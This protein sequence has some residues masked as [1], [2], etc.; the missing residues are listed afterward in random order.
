MWPLQTEQGTHPWHHLPSMNCL[1]WQHQKP[2]S[3]GWMEHSI[4][5]LLFNLSAVDSQEESHTWNLLILKNEM[6][7]LFK[8]LY[9]ECIHYIKCRT[10]KEKFATLQKCPRI[11]V[12]SEVQCPDEIFKNSWDIEMFTQSYSILCFY[13]D[14]SS[15]IE[16][17]GGNLGGVRKNLKISRVT[18]WDH[19]TLCCDKI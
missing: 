18:H 10:M 16:L 13:S 4:K 6:V 3:S 2:L 8:Y 7:I 5:M 12:A 9:N 15:R 14:D 17:W 1:G 11:S 19:T